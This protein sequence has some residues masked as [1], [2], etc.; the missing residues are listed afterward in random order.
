MWRSRLGGRFDD[1]V[2]MTLYG[3]ARWSEVGINPRDG[4]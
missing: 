4:P 2:S 3:V 1:S